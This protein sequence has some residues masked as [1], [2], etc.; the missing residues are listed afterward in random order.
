MQCGVD[1][2]EDGR[3]WG[4]KYDDPEELKTQCGECAK[5]STWLQDADNICCA[6]LI[7]DFKL[8]CLGIW[9]G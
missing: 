9:E 2:C 1:G 7:H 5:P 8:P 6:S 3:V 4:T